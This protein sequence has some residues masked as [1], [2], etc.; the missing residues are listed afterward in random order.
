MIDLRLLREDPDRVRASQRARGEDV[1]LVDALLSADELRRSSGVRF[2]ELRS[3]Q[4]SL[5]KLIPKATP[6]ERTE[7]LKKADQ[8]KTEVKAADAARDE[9][10]AEAKRL[11]LLLG[12]VVHEDVPVGGEEDFVVLE[13]H[14]TIRDFGAEGFEPKDH[15]ELGESLGAIDMERGAKVSGSRFYYLTGVG[16]LLE[17]AL[18]NAAIAQATEAGFVPMLTPALVRPRAMEGTGFLGQAAE[19]VYHLEKDDYY[20]VGTSEV[21]LA[22]YHMDEI[23]E[24]DKLPLRYAGFSPCFRREAGTYGKDTR[25]IF[26]VHQF[27]KV[28][29]F[30]YVDPADAEA[31]HRRLLDWEKQWLT[32]LELPFQVIDVATGDLGASASRKF[33]CEAWIPTQGKYRELT[34]AS[35]CD[36][37]QARRL[38]VRMRDGKKV[39]PLS[40]LN[41]TLC[42]VPRTIVAILENHQLADGSVRVPEILRPYLGGRE[43]LEPV[44]K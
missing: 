36:G 43:V 35:N 23:I 4:K 18:V 3:E 40:T 5:G 13:T 8:L 20:L 32:A 22:A 31:E 15:L 6:E 33:D 39:Q 17:L 28:E 29:M 38:S 21:P 9:A 37:F 2:D 12:N 1:A 19:N 24:A 44:S 7:L 16:A 41:G 25:G 26:R 14:G 27:D 10:D 11:L 30:S 34:S 42:A